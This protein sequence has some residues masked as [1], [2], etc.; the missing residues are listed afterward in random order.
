MNDLSLR[1]WLALGMLF[2]LMAGCILGS[3]FKAVQSLTGNGVYTLLLNVDF[4]PIPE[5]SACPYS[6]L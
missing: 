3:F 2:D 4:L 5:S 6:L 1:L